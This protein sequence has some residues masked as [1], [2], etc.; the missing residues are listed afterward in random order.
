MN[1]APKKCDYTVY[2]RAAVQAEGWNPNRATVVHEYYVPGATAAQA[3]TWQTGSASFP[4]C[5]GA[6]PSDLLV[7]RVTVTITS[8]DDSA[9]RSIQVVKSDV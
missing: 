8:P 1:S 3:G 7:Q 9:R 4:G 6:S 5:P 2:A